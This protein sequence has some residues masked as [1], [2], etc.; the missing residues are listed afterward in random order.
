VEPIHDWIDTWAAVWREFR[1]L[2]VVKFPQLVGS[3]SNL[4]VFFN[5]LL[6]DESEEFTI[7]CGIRLNARTGG[8]F[9]FEIV[10]EGRLVFERI[11]VVEAGE[12]LS[13]ERMFLPFVSAA[14]TEVV[15]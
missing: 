8:E 1:L 14:L 4:G 9:F 15:L 7:E 5:G 6:S 2:A 3:T 12:R 11:R 10:C 13:V